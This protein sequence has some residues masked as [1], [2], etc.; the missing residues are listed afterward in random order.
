MQASNNDTPKKLVDG[1]CLYTHDAYG[2]SKCYNLCMHIPWHNH[3]WLLIM[4]ISFAYIIRTLS[5]VCCLEEIPT[6]QGRKQ[7]TYSAWKGSLGQTAL[8]LLEAST[9]LKALIEI[10]EWFKSHNYAAIIGMISLR[11]GKKTVGDVMS[12]V[13]RKK[14]REIKEWITGLIRN[15]EIINIL[16]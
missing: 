5:K 6:N 7:K 2:L 16:N 8:Y 15:C 1:V 14:E 13:T 4:H 11:L 10:W 9:S 12:D 3:A